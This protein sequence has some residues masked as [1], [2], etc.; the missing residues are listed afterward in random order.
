M[1][2]ATVK[3]NLI[4]CGIS[5]RGS[6]LYHNG[7]KITKDEARKI[8]HNR[9]A[10]IA[11]EEIAAPAIIDDASRLAFNRLNAVTQALFFQ[12]CEQ[13]ME[14][15]K[16]HNLA[17]AALIGKQVPNISLQNAPR[18]SNLKKAGVIERVGNKGGLLQITDLG[19]R[20]FHGQ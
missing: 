5:R 14:A 18:L 20:I 3:D 12:L 17:I 11:V 8:M 1:T 6:A 7:K 4:A 13:I 2:T 16:D 19:R 10:E 15:T 9:P